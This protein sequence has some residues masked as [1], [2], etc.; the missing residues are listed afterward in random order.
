MIAAL[1]G[2]Q[3]VAVYDGFGGDDEPIDSVANQ[4]RSLGQ[5]EAFKPLRVRSTPD[6]N[7]YQYFEEL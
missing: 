4:L 5:K 1:K 2:K 7:L 3:W 6:G